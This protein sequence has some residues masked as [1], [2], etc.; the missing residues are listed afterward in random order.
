MAS[1]FG[2]YWPGNV[3]ELENVIERAVVMCRGDCLTSDDLPAELRESPEIEDSLDRLISGE[4]GLAET[5]EAIE[6][7]MIRQ[8][9]KRASNVQAQAAKALGLSRSNLQY[10]LKKY[11]I[12][13]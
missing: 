7:R 5:L 3:R 11:G 8:A 6:E 10:K 4:K 1:L 2:Y 13:S 9:L 12:S